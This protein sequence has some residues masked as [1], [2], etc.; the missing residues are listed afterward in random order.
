MSLDL[1]SIGTKQNEKLTQ[2]ITEEEINR[3]ISRLKTNKMP[4]AD[5]Y[6]S[7]W[8]KILRK[9]IIP[10]LKDCFNYVLKGGE[11]PP[12]WRQAI[13]S[14]IPKTGKDITD[15]G[16][17]RPISVLNIDYRLFA[18][19]LAIRL[20]DIIPDLIDTDQTGFVKNRHT[21]DNVRRTLYLIEHMKN[22]HTDSLVLSLDAEEAFDSVRWEYLYLALEKFG[23]NNQ[24]ISCLKSLYC[25]PM[26]RIKINGNLSKP[27]SL[28][29]GCRQGC[30]LSPTLFTLF[31]EPLAQT[32]REDKNI[33]GVIIKNTEYKICLY[34]DDILLTLTK[35]QVSL[36]KIL[37]QLKTF[38]TYS[39]YKLNLHKT[40]ILTF[41]YNPQ[42]GVNKK[43][44]FK[45]ENSSIKYLGVHI[46]KDLSAIYMQNY[47]PI[48]AEIKSD[49]NR[50]SSL[51]MNMSNRID[52]IKMNILPRLLFLFQSLPV[53][54]PHKQF[55]EWKRM[56]STFIWGKQKPRIRLRTLQLPKNQGGMAVPCLEDYYKAAQVRFLVCWCNSDLEA[57]WKD[58][59]QS[60][61]DVPLQSILGDKNLL[62][63][64]LVK[65]KNWIT[66][67]LNIWYKELKNSEF[68]RNVR[69]LRWVAYDTEFTPAKLDVRFKYWINR[70]ITSYCTVFARKDIESFQQ[71]TK[72]YSLEKQDFFRYLQMRSY[73]EKNI[74]TVG[75]KGL[76]LIKIFTD[77]YKGNTNRGLISRIYSSLQLEKGF[78]TMYVKSRWEKEANVMLTEDDWTNIC[79]TLSTT[80]SS[81]LWREFT[82]KNILR[83][84]ITPNIKK[85]QSNNP[86]HGQCWRICGNMSAGP[87]HIFWDCPN[88]SEYWVDVVKEIRSILNYDLDFNFSVIYLGNVPAELRNSD[89]YLLQ[90]LL[91]GSK[92]AITKKW[93]SKESPTLS[94]WVEIVQEIYVMEKM[95]FSIRQS[96][97][98][99]KT[100]WGNWKSYLALS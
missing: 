79:R 59:E 17:Y 87:F 71:L 3:A 57:K 18:S 11:P 43:Q 63:K 23:F 64:Y 90:I 32:I 31:I 34:A 53:E 93:L 72:K 2:E 99:F 50:W 84:F 98:R 14:V 75:E 28:E 76:T 51:P 10:L 60:Q 5:G 52:V 37:S 69:I 35:P 27:V 62:K 42:V 86:A 58:L 55:C 16:S 65:M 26:A 39:G 45:W 77:S 85:V 66:V 46:P 30:P 41:N 89:R 82:W 100:Y 80:S 15:C 67:P 81:S 73:F 33:T 68:E 40:Q 48:T 9:I 25:S 83:F 54:I 94:D 49:L 78:S 8:Y 88:I 1:P 12:S 13:I 29:R 92:K 74:K 47:I 38:G 70:G 20:E 24:V 6:P 96:A 56:I 36:P 7:E 21:Q 44:R 4:G 97:K 95:T 61:L 91:A 19:I 22:S